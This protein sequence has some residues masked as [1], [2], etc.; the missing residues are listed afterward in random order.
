MPISNALKP[1]RI[2]LADSGDLLCTQVQAML[3][4]TECEIVAVKDGFEALCRL[5]G[6]RPDLLLI[7]SELPRLS[8]LQVCALLRQSP[9]FNTLPVVV[10]VGSESSLEQTRAMLAGA[11]DCLPKPFRRNELEAVLS[12]LSECQAAATAVV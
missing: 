2:L 10:M 1:C 3:A 9:D 11:S 6:I 8:G 5:P 4:S 12:R 7:A